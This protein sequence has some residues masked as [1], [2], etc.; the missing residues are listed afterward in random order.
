MT[1]QGHE[2]FAPKK[3]VHLSSLDLFGRMKRREEF[4]DISKGKDEFDL[5]SYS[6]NPLTEGLGFHE[7]GENLEGLLKGTHRRN[8]VAKIPQ[9]SSQSL[10]R[11]QK[12][13]GESLHSKASNTLKPFYQQQKVED[14]TPQECAGTKKQALW[15]RAGKFECFF[16]FFLDMIFLI[17]AEVVFVAS[18]FLVARLPF[19]INF[20]KAE[21][22]SLW[23]FVAVLFVAMYLLYFALLDFLGTPGKR[24]VRIR[25]IH[26]HTSETP[27]LGQ[28]FLR[29]LIFLLGLVP[30]GLPLLANLQGRLSQT[31]LVKN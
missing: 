27:S 19:N 29:A 25:P 28:N 5:E 2:G 16:A 10:A 30:L 17:M 26:L 20:F 6:P 15:K 24:L 23:P 11:S 3:T 14:T 13:L 21:W 8:R 1:L 9:S 12:F 22:H 18:F 4:V 7:R 31:R